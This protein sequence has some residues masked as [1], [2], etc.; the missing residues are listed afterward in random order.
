MQRPLQ[1][2]Q[3]QKGHVGRLQ[4]VVQAV[5]L[6]NEQLGARPCTVVLAQLRVAVRVRNPA[7]PRLLNQADCEGAIAAAAAEIAEA[8][9]G[10]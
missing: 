1:P 7:R 5:P 2:L 6:E 10:Q 8:A 4:R 9:K 3:P